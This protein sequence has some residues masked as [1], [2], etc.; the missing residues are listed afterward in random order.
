MT[1]KWDLKFTFLFFYIAV[2]WGGV[3]A[4]VKCKLNT[5]QETYLAGKS[6]CNQ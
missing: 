4:E 5:L 3:E 1:L 6:Y 2:Y